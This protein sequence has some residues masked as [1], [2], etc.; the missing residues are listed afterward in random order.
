MT[1]TA[2][3]FDGRLRELSA[4]VGSDQVMDLF[5]QSYEDLLNDVKQEMDADRRTE[6]A[7]KLRMMLM[8]QAAYL[9]NEYI[10]YQKM[11]TPPHMIRMQ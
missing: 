7:V 11:A 1:M 9:M 3:D 4:M 8:H 5:T 2:Q 6:Q 10:R